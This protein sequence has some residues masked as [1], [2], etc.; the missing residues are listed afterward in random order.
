MP[1]MGYIPQHVLQPEGP[2]RGKQKSM[3]Q[4]GGGACR[5]GPSYLLPSLPSCLAHGHGDPNDGQHVLRMAEP[6]I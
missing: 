5:T 3:Q 2:R 1:T 6:G 4:D